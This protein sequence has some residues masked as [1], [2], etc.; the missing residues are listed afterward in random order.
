MTEKRARKDLLVICSLLVLVT[1]YFTV[2]SILSSELLGAYKLINVIRLFL[3][4]VSTYYVVREVIWTKWVLGVLSLFS[5]AAGFYVAKD[6]LIESIRAQIVT[7]LGLGIAVVSWFYLFAGVY[8]L[9]T[10]KKP[11]VEEENQ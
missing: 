2:R 5:G 4:L 8:I 11:E 9:V 7:L 1:L 3:T 10:I 6:F